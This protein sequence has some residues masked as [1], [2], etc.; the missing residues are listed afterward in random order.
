MGGFIGIAQASGQ[1]AEHGFDYLIE[2]M[3]LLSV[4]LGL[5]N[6][7]PIPMLDGGRLL[8]YL[9]EAVCRRP[10]HKSIQIWAFQI[11]F[12]LILML[13]LITAYNDISRLGLLN[14]FTSH[15]R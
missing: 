5:V 12:G 9:I 3:A 8:F 10:V 7:L 1:Y 6:L 2:F 15:S 14:W 4:N 13:F 11:G